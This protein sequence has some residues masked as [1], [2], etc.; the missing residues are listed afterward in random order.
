MVNQILTDVELNGHGFISIWQ[1]SAVNRRIVHDSMTIYIAVPSFEYP[2]LGAIVSTQQILVTKTNNDKTWQDLFQI[3]RHHHH[4]VHVAWLNNHASREVPTSF[5]KG[6]RIG[7]FLQLAGR[8]EHDFNSCMQK[9][10]C[11]KQNDCVVP[12]EGTGN[13]TLEAMFVFIKYRVEII[14]FLHSKVS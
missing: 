3:S 14:L 1:W 6:G 11:Q 4:L 5:R 2:K 7:G 9:R 8:Q 10:W 13:L 12:W